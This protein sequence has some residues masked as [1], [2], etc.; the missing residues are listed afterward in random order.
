ELALD[1]VLGPVSLTTSMP[2]P[3]AAQLRKALVAERTLRLQRF[4]ASDYRAD[5][6]VSDA[7]IAAWYEEH[8]TEFTLPEQVSV[9]YILLNEAAAMKGLPAV[10]EADLK[11]YYEQNKSRYVQP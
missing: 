2:A 3:V 9:Q 6:K 7:D 8:K 10:S 1:R 11:Q 5:I 4:E